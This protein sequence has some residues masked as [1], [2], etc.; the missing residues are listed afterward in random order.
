[1]IPR[2]LTFATAILFAVAVGMSLYVWQLRRRE[3]I[4]PHPVATAQHGA[5]P[6]SGPMEKATVWV[7]SDD[8]G[9]LRPRAVSIPLA[10]GTPERAPGLMPA[11]LAIYVGG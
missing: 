8:P 10:G 6:V 5:P 11:L 3:T 9:D 1:M 7:A 4:N 2:Q